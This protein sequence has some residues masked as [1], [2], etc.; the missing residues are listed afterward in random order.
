MMG[1][2]TETADLNHGSS[3]TLDR[4]LGS[5]HGT[6]L[7]LLH[8]CD[9]CVACAVCGAPGFWKPAPQAGLHCPAL[10]TGEGARSCLK[11]MCFV[12]V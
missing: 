1:E 11:L 5:L 12:D 9:S 8:M 10:I 6:D 4:Q 2:P 3:W 7:G